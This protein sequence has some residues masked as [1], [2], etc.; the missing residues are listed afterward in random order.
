MIIDINKIPKPK[1]T[2]RF[3]GHIVI[4]ETII[5]IPFEAPKNADDDDILNELIYEFSENSKMYWEE[6]Y[7]G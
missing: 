5:S 3:M 2:R 6:I 1:K 7:N 4:G